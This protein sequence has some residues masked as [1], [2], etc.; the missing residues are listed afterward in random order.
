MDTTPP[1]ISHLKGLMALSPMI[2]FVL[3]FLIASLVAH[4]FSKV[5]LTA[6]FFIAAVYAILTTTAKDLPDRVRAFSRGVGT[7]KVLLII[8]IIFIAGI[9]AQTANGMGG[10]TETV[11]LILTVLS[12]KFLYAG[13]FLAACVISMATGSAFGSVAALAPICAGMIDMAQL[14]PGFTI[15]IVV[16]GV[17]FGDNLSFISDTTIVVTSTQGCKMA[18]KFKV[19]I[20]LVLPVAIVLFFVYL[21]LGKDIVLP[22]QTYD[23]DYIK[24]IPYAAVIILAICGIDVF[25]VLLI[26]IILTA[27]LGISYGDY[28]F[29]SFLGT[30]GKGIDSVA[31][32][33]IVI[34]FA[35]GIM[36]I[37]KENGGVD[38]LLNC[39]SKIVKGKRSAQFAISMLTVIIN[40]CTAVNTVALITVSPIAKEIS[41]KYGLDNR[42]V[43]SLLDTSACASQ[44]LL[45]YGA[46]LLLG[47]SLVGIS[48]FDMLP[49]LYYPMLILLAV[50][51]AITFNLPRKYS[52]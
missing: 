1:K 31:E 16:G 18:D 48:A 3:F 4:D 50:I 51:V 35:A 17:F 41:N 27:V 15:A 46:H 25:I 52:K 6:T 47:A 26:G 19:N 11:E 28:D 7:T 29:Y 49:Y 40:I 12:S 38:Y 21:Y 13:L 39:I 44:G 34:L 5:S 42:K 43:A 32:T 9:F 22:E 23:I 45:P 20:R 10:V 2:F 33:V 24:I 14:N 30:M 36:G 37:V 8:W